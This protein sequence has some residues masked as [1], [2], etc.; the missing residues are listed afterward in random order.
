M[1]ADA[2][3]NSGVL[4]M[5]PMKQFSSYRILKHPLSSPGSFGE[6]AE[7]EKATIL[8][9]SNDSS[10]A[11]FAVYPQNPEFPLTIPD[12]KDAAYDITIYVADGENLAGGYIGQ[13]KVS[14]SALSSASEVVFH[15][16]SHDASSEDEQALFAAGLDSYSK[17]V[18][19]PEMK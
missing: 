14:K 1:Q 2:D 3:G 18:P 8:I 5:N 11:S 9:S 16:V 4:R 13:W 7:D 10:Y 15:V 12:G 6:L 17:K 19:Q